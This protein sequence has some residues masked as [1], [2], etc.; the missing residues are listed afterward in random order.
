MFKKDYQANVLKRGLSSENYDIYI[1][2]LDTCPDG[3][4][5]QLYSVFINH[6]PVVD[7]K[8]QGY[9]HVI[10]THEVVI[11]SDMDLF[12]DKRGQGTGFYH[13]CAHW[14]DYEMGLRIN[15][16]YGIPYS[17]E[18][19][20]QILA[21]NLIKELENHLYLH[22]DQSPDH[23]LNME[24]INE[25]QKMSPTISHGISTLA[26]GVTKGSITR[27]LPYGQSK[28]YWGNDNFWFDQ[29]T[30]ECF[31]EMMEASVSSPEALLW[32]EKNLPDTYQSF[33]ELTELMLE[34]LM[35]SLS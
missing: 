25:L 1:D 11:D 9:G 8:N 2:L 5:K 23:I 15:G 10:G 21:K 26:D 12:K 31:A 24:F 17:V 34:D 3:E 28:S 22:N 18:F 4:V 35:D 30:K 14:I 20:G 27:L 13:E 29:L 7:E 16:R 32:M 19:S 6:I 33:C